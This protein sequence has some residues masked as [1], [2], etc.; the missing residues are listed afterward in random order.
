MALT[1][2]LTAI[3]D[4]I[5]SKTGGTA[6]LTLDAMA[7]AIAAIEAGGGGG[8]G[9]LAWGV[10]TP[11]QN[12]TEI[13]IEHG[14]PSTPRFG[15]ILYQT[16]SWAINESNIVVCLMKYWKSYGVETFRVISSGSNKLAF[17][18]SEYSGT[19]IVLWDEKNISFGP[20]KAGSSTDAEFIGGRPYMW[21]AS[22]YP[23]VL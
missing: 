8:E 20:Y 2:K 13:V 15:F 21:V 23:I 12:E 6:S 3:A 17:H 7:Q 5:R 1:D 10:I 18:T 11:A 16:A 9:A 4:A 14:L 19:K 22:D